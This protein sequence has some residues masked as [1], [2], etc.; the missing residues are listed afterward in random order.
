M[1]SAFSDI[2]SGIR[3]EKGISQR[4]AAADLKISQALL[5]H[6][7]NG[8]RE[9]GL[10]FI[11][12]ACDYYG[13]SA[14]FLLG[15]TESSEDGALGGV[16]SEL[17]ALRHAL[18]DRASAEVEAAVAKYIAATARLLSAEIYGIADTRT[19]ARSA[20]EQAEA[21]HAIVSLF[22]AE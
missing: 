2:L 12:R 22:P 20:L 15:R 17:N 6:Y 16:F 13:V 19:V 10:P 8:A 11:C 7:E 3:H 21:E 9:P 18:H 1:A 4:R 5:S 14:D